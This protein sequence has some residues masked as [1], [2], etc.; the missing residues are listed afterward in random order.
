M[1]HVFRKVYPD[2]DRFFL[3][4]FVGKVYHLCLFYIGLKPFTFFVQSF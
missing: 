2:L 3:F 4:T 1:F